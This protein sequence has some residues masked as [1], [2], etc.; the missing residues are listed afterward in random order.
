LGTNYSIDA[1][2]VYGTNNVLSGVDI[3][4]SDPAADNY[5]DITYHIPQAISDGDVLLTV[6][7]DASID[8]KDKEFK[9]VIT[10]DP[11]TMRYLDEHLEQGD[12]VKLL[13]GT[14]GP[15]ASIRN[16]KPGSLTDSIGLSAFFYEIDENGD[17]T[18]VQ[19]SGHDSV[20][21]YFEG[22]AAAAFAVAEASRGVESAVDAMAAETLEGQFQIKLGFLGQAVENETG[23]S[24]DV[25][26]FGYSLAGGRKLETGAGAIT[27]G[28]FIEGGSG[29]YDTFN[30]VAGIGDVNGD[31][32]TDYFGGGLFVR[33]DFTAGTWV[34]FAARIGSV[35]NDYK[36][37]ALAS[38]RISFQTDSGY[39][40]VNAGLGHVFEIS[41]AS[42]VNLYGRI[43]WTSVD[44]DDLKDGRG[45]ELRFDDVKSF[46]TRIGAT[47]SR[48][49][50]E[51]VSGYAGLAWEQEF[52]G[53]TG[54]T[55]KDPI[56]GKTFHPTSPDPSGASAYGEIGLRI[57]PNEYVAFQLE[58]F[59]LVGQSKGGGG[60]ASLVFTF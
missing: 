20:K 29:S 57:R 54:G 33:H 58:A 8:F 10:I 45:G 13:D 48:S 26:Q 46:R 59:G 51:I 38:E 12:T 23:S 50:S 3:D 4:V 32:D 7:A 21:P 18:L 19:D 41:E 44:G 22:A 53:K 42:S 39:F 6:A 25:S 52:D 36:V 28:A 56:T 47:F 9:D 14:A 30:S 11:S 5:A 1:I 16:L 35:E 24:V 34:S 17:I 37:Q 40:G 55:Y 49:F 31:G 15:T 60:L 2:D 43:A 27:F